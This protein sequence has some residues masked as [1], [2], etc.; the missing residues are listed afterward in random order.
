MISRMKKFLV[1][2]L[3]PLILLAL[4]LWAIQGVGLTLV[5]VKGPSM[6]PSYADGQ[7][8]FVNRLAYGLQSPII[9]HYLWMWKAPLVGDPVVVRKPDGQWVVKRIAGLPGMPM[10]VTGHSLELGTREVS[11]SPS[12]EYWLSSCPNV[13]GGSVFV[14]GDNSDRSQ[15]SRDWGFVAVSD[16]LGRAFF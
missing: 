10:K 8:L 4:M 15:D 1:F 6:V 14:L 9:G 2:P 3:A 16:V 13:P 5:R 11:L 7:V 12:Q